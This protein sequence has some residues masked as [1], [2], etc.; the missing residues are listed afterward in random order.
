MTTN[1]NLK[2]LS[3]NNYEFV[4]DRPGHDYMYKQNLSKIKKLGLLESSNFEINLKKT[5][6]WY[7]NN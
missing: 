5:I 6:D 1:S 4:T 3:K 2:N 7:L